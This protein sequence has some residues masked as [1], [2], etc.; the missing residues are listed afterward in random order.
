MIKLVSP[1]RRAF[2]LVELLGVTALIATIAT[3][4]IISIKDTVAAGQRSAVQKELQGLNT[5]LNNF[6]AAGGVILDGATVNDA[7]AALKAGTP[8]GGAAYSPLTSLPELSK[9]VAGAQYSLAYDP[10]TGFSYV[11]SGE[12]IGE[13]FAGAGASDGV[14]AN[15]EAYPFDITDPS[16]VDNAL[17]EF[18]GMSPT[19]SNYQNYIDA[20]VAA[21]SFGAISNEQISGIETAFLDKGL[22]K[23]GS[24]PLFDVSS[25]SAALTAAQSLATLRSDATAYPEMI[26]SLNLALVTLTGNDKQAVNNA[27]TSELITN[28]QMNNFYNFDQRGPIRYDVQRTKSG[29]ITGSDWTGVNLTGVYLDGC[30]LT[31]IDVSGA[32]LSKAASLYRTN[33]AGTNLSGLNPSGLAMFGANLMGATGIDVNL[34]GAASPI[35][36]ADL[37]GTGISLATLREAVIKAGKNPNYLTTNLYD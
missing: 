12:V 31:G 14:G 37:R 17:A 5:S 21:E 2:T 26:D 13:V 34:L 36:Y 22:T 18:S 32:Q 9:T 25:P 29:A 30:D 19:D 3:I 16:A 35:M 33:L 27:M 6:K 8:L 7:L 23:S 4:S 15:G 1:I 10:V 24:E 11:P 28:T 20:L